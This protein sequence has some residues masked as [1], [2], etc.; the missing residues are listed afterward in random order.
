ME[1]DPG[2]AARAIPLTVL[3]G[4]SRFEAAPKDRPPAVRVVAETP[5][6]SS[7]P[8]PPGGAA[9][10]AWSPAQ[11]A[12]IAAELAGAKTRRLA[13]PH[14]ILFRHW[15]KRN[16]FEE[17][18]LEL[19]HA[20]ISVAAAERVARLLWGE[21]GGLGLVAGCRPEISRR[22]AAWLERKIPEPQVYVFFQPIALKQKIAGES[23]VTH[24][25]AAVGINGAGLREG[26]AVAAGGAAAEV[27]DRLLEGLKA[28][29]LHGTRLFVGD[30]ELA[31]PAAVAR[32]FPEARYQ[33]CLEQLE[34]DVLGRVPVSQVHSLMGGFE[35]LRESVD[36]TQ[37]GAQLLALGA[38]LRQD[39]LV[40]AATLVAQCAGFQ[41]SYLRFPPRH[42]GRL[43]DTEPLKSVLRDFR[44]HLRLI[45]PVADPEIL[46]LM[47]ATRMRHAAEQSWSQ[48]R[49]INF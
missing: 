4:S 12:A 28:R 36:E 49:Y 38:R 32:H 22:I 47:V 33:G 27:W 29:G 23:R 17:A 16:S 30:N 1:R 42:R 35:R 9:G 40:E 11:D 13:A 10:T 3:A 41:F 2:V 15:K 5:W 43:R 19:Y 21:R 48:R 14:A 39:R 6:A 7:A 34:R 45:G 24:L 46:A 44:E 8:F 31:A 26:L 37:A 20:S 25:V 18:V